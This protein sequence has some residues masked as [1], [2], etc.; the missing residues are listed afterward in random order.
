MIQNNMDLSICTNFAS[1]TG[2]PR[3]YLKHIAD[4]GFSHIHWS[5]E[6]I[7]EHIY[8]REEQEELLELL[9]KLHLKLSAMHGSI[10][11]GHWFAPDENN[12]KKAVLLL[13]NR[14]EMTW[15]LGGN[16]VVMHPFSFSL[17]TDVGQELLTQM[18]KSIDDV[19]PKV[20]E[21]GIVIALENTANG[22]LPIIDQI[23]SEYDSKHLGFCFDI[24]HSLCNGGGLELLE[25]YGNR[26]SVLHLHDNNGSDDQHLFPFDGNVDW[27]KFSSLISSTAYTGPLNFEIH[28]DDIDDLKKVYET[29]VKITNMIDRKLYS[30][31]MIM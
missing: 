19:L 30:N 9:D 28:F 26:L 23:F 4:A 10:G 27:E 11:H 3:E 22:S 2:C 15:R 12:R 20:K 1:S 5:H 14:L 17:S 29:G 8:T 24:G 31:K 6:W 7:T 21:Y 13:L 25:K 16:A 18:K